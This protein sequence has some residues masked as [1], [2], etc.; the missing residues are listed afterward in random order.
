M[1]NQGQDHFTES[2]AANQNKFSSELKT[3]FDYVVC[4]AGTWGS[5]MTA[6]LVCGLS[7]AAKLHPALAAGRSWN[8]SPATGLSLSGISVAQQRWAGIPCL[9]WT[10]N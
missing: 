1:K 9:W 10:A 6:R 3:K 4:G 5:V 8:D 2:V 7:R